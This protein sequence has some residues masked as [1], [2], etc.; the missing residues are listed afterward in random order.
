M[1]KWTWDFS[2]DGSDDAIVFTRQSDGLQ[3]Y[4]THYS[5]TDAMTL[6][7]YLNSR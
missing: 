7:M 2:E 3:F 1:K 4:R 6:C 5:A